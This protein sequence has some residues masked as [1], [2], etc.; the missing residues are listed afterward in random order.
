[1]ERESMV[2]YT[3][4]QIAGRVQM[5]QRA[6]EIAL[7]YTQGL[8]LNYFPSFLNKYLQAKERAFYRLLQEYELEFVTEQE[9]GGL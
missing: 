4:R 6:H 5:E 3:A 2:T 8:N 7:A 9:T 1:M